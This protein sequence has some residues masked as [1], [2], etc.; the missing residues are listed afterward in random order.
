MRDNLIVASGERPKRLD[1]YLAGHLREL[2]RTQLQRL[3]TLGRIRVRGRKAKPSQ[4]VHGGDRIE[5][6]RPPAVP[7]Q[8][9]LSQGL[10]PLSEDEDI[11]VVDKPAGVVMH[12][13]SGHWDDTIV[14]AVL[15]HFLERGAKE[16]LPKLV[17]R[18]DK[19]TSGV[20]LIAKTLQAHQSLSRQFAE[21]RIT[22]RY[23]ALVRGAPVLDQDRI[24]LA[25][26][27]DRRDGTIVSA[28]ASRPKPAV[29]R[30][31]ILHRYGDVAARLLLI[32]GTGRTHQLRAHLQAIEHPILG[33][34]RYGG[35]GAGQLG[36]IPIGRMMLHAEMIGYWHPRTGQYREHFAPMPAELLTLNEV[37]RS[38]DDGIR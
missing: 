20:V 17:H 2:S 19:G 1:H 31:Q 13:G 32:P 33:D 9:H 29:T 4:R 12:P 23:I 6:Q 28:N 24:E 22:R 27:R 26:G 14:N 8:A 37:L 11:L 18:L 35:P 36:P 5:F 7:L 30:Y 3:I 10:T 16:I 21:H 25:I 38:S 15:H 34:L